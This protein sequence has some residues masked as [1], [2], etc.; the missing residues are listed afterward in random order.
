MGDWL[1]FYGPPLLGWAL[2]LSLLPHAYLRPPDLARRMLAEI[3]LA[4]TISLTVL[5]PAVYSAIGQY[6][7]VPNLARP[8]GH[9]SMLTAAWSAQ[10]LLRLLSAPPS[11]LTTRQRYAHLWVLVPAFAIL[12]VLFALAPTPVDDVRFAGRYAAAPW[13]FEYWMV[14]LAFLTPAF[15]NLVR[16]A[17][18]YARMAANSTLSLGLRLAAI[19]A[20]CGLAYHV[21]KAFVFGAARFGFQYLPQAESHVLDAVLPLAGHVL[22]LAGATM[23]TWGPLLGLPALLDWFQRYHTYLALRPLWLALYR[24]SP[25]IALSPPA[26]AP[27]DLLT[28]RDLGLRLY[29]RVIEIRDGRMTLQP[30]LDPGVAAAARAAAVRAGMGGQRLEAVVE[31]AT[32]AAALRA[33]ARGAAAVAHP[34]A[35][36]IPGGGD[37]NSDIAFLLD[38]ARAY[39]RHRPRVS[40]SRPTSAAG[41]GR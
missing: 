34:P 16:F 32:L 10:T 18:R 17:S 22:F 15:G 40:V 26:S 3:L 24:A 9:A 25:Q 13:V 14:Y 28:V 30:Y 19:G 39:R 20:V 8:L 23:P 29:R 36:A 21:H 37:L 7:G 31:A 11:R 27:A 5:T 41:A 4:V 33:K 2:L 35:T 38:V 6:S 1:R 12:G